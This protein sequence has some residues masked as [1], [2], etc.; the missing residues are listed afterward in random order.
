MSES[1]QAST[2]SIPFGRSAKFPSASFTWKYSPKTPSL[3]LENFQ[4]ASIPPECMENPACA[5]KEF[6]S[7][8]IAGT[9]TR[10]PT[11]KSLTISPT[12]T[13]SAQHSCPKIMLCLSPIAPSQ[14]VCTSEV[15]I[16]TAS[17]VQMASIGPHAGRSFSIHP[18]SPIFSIA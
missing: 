4:P 15:Q 12:S 11:L 6:Q 17:G 18:D 1:I 16:A 5:S 10:S 7:G 13:I 3:K 2:G 14:R 8:V 9:R